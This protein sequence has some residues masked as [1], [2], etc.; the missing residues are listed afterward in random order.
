MN[1]HEYR[2]D[3][4]VHLPLSDGDAHRPRRSIHA[5]FCLRVRGNVNA[6][7]EILA[8][9]LSLK[10]ADLQLAL[11]ILLADE[12]VVSS[13]ADRDRELLIEHLL[14]LYEGGMASRF[15]ITQFHF[16]L[17]PATS[18]LRLHRIERYGDDLSEWRTSLVLAN[19]ERRPV[20]G[21]EVTRTGPGLKVVHPIMH[22]NTFTKDK[23]IVVIILVWLIGPLYH[24]PTGLPTTRMDGDRCLIA[25]FWPSELVRRLYGLV[26]VTFMFLVPVLIQ[27]YCYVRIIRVLRRRTRLPFRGGRDRQPVDNFSRAQRNVVKTLVIVSLCYVLCWTG[28]QMCYLLFNLGMP[29]DFA[30]P[31]YHVSVIAVFSNC[32]INPFVYIFKYEEF[33]LGMRKLICRTDVQ[34]IETSVNGSGS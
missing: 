18:F 2:Q 3:A 11:E 33:Q 14:P 10:S 5:L 34:V 17:P 15:D 30:S 22:K 21:I 24:F 7:A 31:F 19:S 13:F 29:F 27:A 16:H 8:E 28:N 1:E 32:C 4:D 26:T 12:D 25:A 6:F 9:Q 23:A 20:T